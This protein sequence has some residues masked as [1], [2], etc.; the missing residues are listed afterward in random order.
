MMVLK[1]CKEAKCVDPWGTLHPNGGVRSLAD[2]LDKKYDEF[3]ETQVKVEYAYC[4]KGYILD[5]EGPMDYNV[6]GK[7]QE[8]EM[9]RMVINPNWHLWT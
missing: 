8:G 2:A 6:Y 3:Y 4:V 9:K 7:G 1:S 5:A